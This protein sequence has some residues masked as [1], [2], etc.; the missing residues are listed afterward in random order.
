MACNPH[1]IKFCKKKIFKKEQKFDTEK[2]TPYIT[3][4]QK[5]DKCEQKNEFLI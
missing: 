3:V 2:N 5:Y 1:T 4:I